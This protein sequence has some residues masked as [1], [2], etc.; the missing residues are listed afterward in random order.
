[1]EALQVVKRGELSEE[2]SAIIDKEIDRIISRHKNNRYEI[3]RLVF[4]SMTALTTSENYSDELHSQGFLKRLWGGITGQNRE[5]QNKIDRSLAAAQYASQQTLQ[6]L[7]EQNLMSFELITAVNN[8]LNS[9]LVQIEDEINTIYGTLVTFFKQTKSDIIQLEQRIERLEKNVNLLNWQNSIE[10]QM[11]DGVEYEDLDPISKII[12][13]TRDFYDLT[14]GRWTTSDLLLLKSAMSS[15]GISPKELVNYK[16]FI[17]VVSSNERLMTK[18]FSG[19]DV[20]E[21]EKYLEYIVITAGIKKRYLLDTTEKMLVNSTM[22]LISQYSDEVTESEIGDN[23]LDIYVRDQA[24]IKI[25]SFVNS[26]DMILEL[27]YNLEQIREI[28]KIQKAE[29]KLNEAEALFGI[30]DTDNLIPLL[31]EM[32]Q[33]GITKAKYI[34]ALLFETGC[35]SLKRDDE[36]CDILLDECIEEGYLP[37]IVRKYLPLNR[38]GNQKICKEE[39]PR[40]LNNLEK[41]AN[42]GD[43]FASY[44]CASIYIYWKWAGLGNDQSDR[45]YKKAI[46]YFEASP[47]VLGLYGMAKRYDNGQG[48]KKD[49]AKA[50]ELYLIAANLGYNPAQ[51]KVGIDYH[52]G[53]GVEENPKLAFEYYEKA[54]K[55]GN[56]DAICQCGWCLTKEFGTN[57]DYKRAFELF[58][59]GAE[60]NDLECI[61][62]LGWHYH[63]GYYVNKDMNKAKEYYQKAA[64]MGSEYSKKQ[65]KDYF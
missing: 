46:E 35:K 53:C 27:L 45:E 62:N 32:I 2:T 64:D 6:K 56:R 1:M 10:Y 24:K 54:Y 42:A 14:A 19:M 34:M 61:S 23:L 39:F 43:K 59:E 51:Y 47:H 29:R 37:A 40:I 15:I 12:C 8:K 21:I 16:N 33:H 50:F 9:S 49:Y 31:E 38:I 52:N 5:L 44:E 36:K 13:L 25:D 3:N 26:Y 28:E 22:E 20:G 7:A 11:F 17:C 57:N 30:Y 63:W 41:M 60:L 58:T 55:N 65:L 4:Q 48:V 18:L